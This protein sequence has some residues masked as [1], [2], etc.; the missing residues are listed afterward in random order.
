[1]Y[2]RMIKDVTK[3]TLFKRTQ[4]HLVQSTEC[5]VQSTEYSLQSKDYRV[6]SIECQVQCTEH[7]ALVLIVILFVD[8]NDAKYARRIVG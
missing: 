5:R 8:S 1:M 6:Q 3:E 4:R 2:D 7:R